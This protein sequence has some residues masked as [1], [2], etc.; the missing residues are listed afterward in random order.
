MAIILD[1]TI[2]TYLHCSGAFIR[3]VDGPVT[4]KDTAELTSPGPGSITDLEA[5][6]REESTR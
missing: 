2:G 3:H 6:Y 1:R 5:E 4:I